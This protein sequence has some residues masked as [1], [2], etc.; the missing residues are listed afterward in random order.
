V[1]ADM[2]GRRFAVQAKRIPGPAI[3]SPQRLVPRGAQCT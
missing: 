2:R 3:L 1:R